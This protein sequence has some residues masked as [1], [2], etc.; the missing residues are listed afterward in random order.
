MGWVIPP[1]S[2]GNSSANALTAE[3]IFNLELLLFL[4]DHF[5]FISA[6]EAI[7][8]SVHERA[9]SATQLRSKLVHTVI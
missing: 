1:C 5:L 9:V 4:R 6:A 8:H 2:V 3:L 7:L